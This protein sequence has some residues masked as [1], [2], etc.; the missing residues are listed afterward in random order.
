MI[1]E[2][3]ITSVMG[4][5]NAEPGVDIITY[6]STEEAEAEDLKFEASLG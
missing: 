1:I 2:I 5:E 4:T 6:P 3:Q